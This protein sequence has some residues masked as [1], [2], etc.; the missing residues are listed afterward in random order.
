MIETEAIKF[1][2]HWTSKTGKDATKLDWSRTWQ[3]W[4]LNARIPNGH[5]KPDEGYKPTVFNFDEPKNSFYP[6]GY[7]PP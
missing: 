6:K 4:V 1:R 5:A 3:N 7:V 2:N